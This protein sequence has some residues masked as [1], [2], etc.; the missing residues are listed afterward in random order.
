MR[1]AGAMLLAAAA[2]LKA[3]AGA[4]ARAKT[5]SGSGTITYGVAVEW[6][7]HDGLVLGRMTAPKHGV[8]GPITLD[9][10]RIG[11]N[12]AGLLSYLETG[13]GDWSVE[14]D[15]GL[16]ARG[17]FSW[18]DPKFVMT[19]DGKDGNGDTVKFIVWPP[20]LEPPPK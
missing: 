11:R 2:A 6:Q 9:L 15:D 18:Q 3:V 20:S 1:P 4:A 16:T 19:G 17:K 10:D 5:A 14:C 13:A 8:D 7:G 12:C